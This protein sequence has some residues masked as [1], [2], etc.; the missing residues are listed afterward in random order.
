MKPTFPA[1]R[2]VLL[3]ALGAASFATVPAQAKTH[4]DVNVGIGAP[5][6]R[7]YA[8]VRVGPDRYYYHRGVYYRPGP[9]GYTVVR[10][11]R[12]AF[13]RVLPPHYT[14][15]YV[16]GVYYYRYGDVYYQPYR[17][18]YVV[19]DAPPAVVASAPAPVAEPD[20][21]VWVGNDEYVFKDG[22]F[23]R[24]NA[25]GLVWAPTPVGATIHTLPSDAKSVWYQENEYFEAD[26]VYFKKTPDGYRV[27]DAPWKN[28][29]PPPPPGK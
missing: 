3:I 5:I 20:Q 19:V 24:K 2:S 27:I 17:D 26:D 4:V 16:G 8:E 7:G 18:G 6:P 13:I 15:I 12:G 10:A 25:D 21:T 29:V 22:Q 11:P 23:F 1:L 9:R 14:R 28:G